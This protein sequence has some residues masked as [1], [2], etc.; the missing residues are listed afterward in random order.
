MYYRSIPIGEAAVGLGGAFTG[1]ADDPSA[2]YYN[3]AGLVRGGRFSLLGSF[4]SVVF[5]KSKIKDAFTA[6]GEEETFTSKNTTTVPRFVGTTVKMGPK[7]FGNDHQFAVGYSTVEVA[8]NKTNIGITQNDAAATLDL[9]VDNDYNS[10]WY[11]ISFAAEVTE[12]SAV[13][14]TLFLSDQSLSYNEN[15][16]LAAGGTFDEQTGLRVDGNS[17]TS[18]SQAHVSAYHFVPRLGW[19]HRIDSR[20]SIGV[21]LQ[22]PGIPLKQKGNVLR[23]LTGDEAAVESVFLLFNED[24]LK[25]QMPVPFEL[26]AGFGFQVTRDTLISFDAAVT[27]PVKDRPL[28]KDSSALSPIDGELGVYL[29]ANTGRR[30]APN[31]AVGAEHQFG[32]TVVSGG[33]FTNYSAAPK[34][35][36]TSNEFVPSQVNLWGA[37]VAVGLDTKGYRLSL[38]ANGMFGKGKALAAVVDQNGDILSYQRTEATGGALILYIAGALSIAT[39]TAERVQEKHQSKRKAGSTPSHDQSSDPNAETDA[40]TP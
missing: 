40:S 38:G 17:I 1:V 35:P 5:T 21:M 32:K 27:G 12:C 13:G 26:R 9:R 2:T 36:A 16:G 25:A 30:W 15:I 24:K 28:F 39:K 4:S 29:P 18:S 37:S 14:F 33:L 31:F 19:I 6:P 34:V 20:W 11:G 10:R 23:R 8:D 3:P 7:K 22:T